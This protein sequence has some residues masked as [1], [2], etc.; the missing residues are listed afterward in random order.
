MRKFLSEFLEEDASRRVSHVESRES[1]VKGGGSGYTAPM[2]P[3]PKT[4]SKQ[5]DRPSATSASFACFS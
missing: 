2:S 4:P 5:S 3:A 1:S